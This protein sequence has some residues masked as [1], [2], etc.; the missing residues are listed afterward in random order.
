MEPM[1]VLSIIDYNEMIIDKVNFLE[2]IRNVINSTYSEKAFWDRKTEIIKAID[3][4]LEKEK[5][6]T[7]K[8]A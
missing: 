4:I 8:S 6:R 7:I 3:D 5:K 1:V 2:N